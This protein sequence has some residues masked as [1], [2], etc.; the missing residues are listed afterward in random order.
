VR[1]LTEND[2]NSQKV[3]LNLRTLQKNKKVE[4]EEKNLAGQQKQH[5]LIALGRMTNSQAAY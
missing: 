2:A 1:K 5:R 4:E 3:L